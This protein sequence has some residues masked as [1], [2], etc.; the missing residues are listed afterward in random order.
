MK[1]WSSTFQA[2]VLK[3]GFTLVAGVLVARFLGPEGR[4]ELTAAIYWSHLLAGVLCLSIDEAVTVRMAAS[5]LT[6]PMGHP[7]NRIGGTGLAVTII[8]A[9]IGIIVAVATIPLLLGEERQGLANLAILYAIAFFPLTLIDLHVKAV[10][11]GVSRFATF[12]FV[13]LIQPL[14]YSVGVV[15]VLLFASLSYQ[16]VAIVML[17][18]LALSVII[19]LVCTIR[20]YGPP[21]LVAARDLVSVGT[22]FHMVNL[23]GYA[24]REIDKVVVMTMLSTTEIGL[25]TVAFTVASIGMGLVVQSIT[26]VMVP[27]ISSQATTEMQNAVI[28]KYVRVSMLLSVSMNLVLFFLIPI[29]LPLFF[30]E[31]FSPAVVVSQLLI[32]ATTLKGLSTTAE[33]AVRT[34]MRIAPGI[35]SQIT[36]VIVFASLSFLMIPLYGLIGVGLS[37][38]LGQVAGFMV[39]LHWLTR[40]LRINPL[41]LWGL[42]V[43]T[44]RLVYATA[45]RELSR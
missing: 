42:N 19:G 43:S 17:S 28:A 26:I 25:Y 16:R 11:Q 27:A 44:A 37:L 32:V 38:I 30:G 35:A 23:L 6:A 1:K 45:R 31:K 36:T 29:L 24:A 2:S 3:F 41:E 40:R 39:L 4:G 8:L 22:R 34:T 15:A 33:R 21:T 10:L 7:I 20:Y 9:V 18:A 12:N 14:V 5:D 13:R